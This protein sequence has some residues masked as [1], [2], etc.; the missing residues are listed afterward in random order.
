MS[1][2]QSPTLP[3][4]PIAPKEYDQTYEN[5]R[6]RQI[7]SNFYQQAARTALMG[8]TLNLNRLPTSD[9]GLRSGDIWVDAG[10]SYVLKMV[11]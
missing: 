11:P 3:P 7:D 10:S 5:N 2:G 8:T 9:T 1:Q 6:N 4:M